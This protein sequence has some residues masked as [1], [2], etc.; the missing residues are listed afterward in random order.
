MSGKPLLC[1]PD[2][3]VPFVLATD[4]STVGLGAVLMQDQGSGPPPIG[5][6]SRVNDK[7]QVEYPVTH[8]ECLAVVWAVQHFRRYLYGRR[9]T[10][11]TDHNAL[12]WLMTKRDLTGKLHRWAL[13]LQEYE[14]EIE[15]RPGR[16]NVVPEALSRAPLLA[17][18]GGAEDGGASIKDVTETT[19]DGRAG[20]RTQVDEAA[21]CRHQQASDQCM[22]ALASG[23]VQ[24]LKV[25]ERDG[26]VYVE[27]DEG[28]RVL[29]PPVLRSLVLRECHESV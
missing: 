18:G 6:T 16:E 17:I 19:A 24:K 7:H 5:Y 4:A 26:I 9:F 10:I 1:Y 27:T 15:Y 3:E 29:L 8:L 25:E 12:K 23:R 14:I 22:R 21:I 13:A 2:F 20:Q 11:I 28:W